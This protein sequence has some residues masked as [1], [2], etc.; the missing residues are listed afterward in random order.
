MRRDS[1]IAVSDAFRVGL[2]SRSR[3]A[4]DEETPLEEW[5]EEPE[6]A[7]RDLLGEMELIALI[8]ITGG[9]LRNASA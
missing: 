7:G 1:S 4:Q 2:P 6:T 5:P 3:R 9:E 8:M